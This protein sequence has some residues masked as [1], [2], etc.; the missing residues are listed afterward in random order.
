[1]Y[2]D[3][4][5]NNTKLISEFQSKMSGLSLTALSEFYFEK[6]AEFE[7]QAAFWLKLGIKYYEK[8]EPENVARHLI[9]FALLYS[10]MEQTLIAEGLYRK[11]LEIL[12]N[13]KYIVI[14]V[15]I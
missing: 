4:E 12:K 8:Y 10:Q 2:Q 15:V 3:T 7:K 5:E 14:I 11:S 9:I 13:V 6:G 1:M